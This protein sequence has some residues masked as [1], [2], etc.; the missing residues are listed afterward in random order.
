[1]TYGVRKGWRGSDWAIYRL[2]AKAI[3][4]GQ[5]SAPDEEKAIKVAIEDFEIA[6]P[7]HQQRLVARRAE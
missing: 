3:Y 5:V 4:L 6:N 1:V 7:H 2:S